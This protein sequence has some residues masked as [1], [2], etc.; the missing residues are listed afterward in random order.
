VPDPDAIR[1]LEQQVADADRDL[2]DALNRRA[3]ARATLLLARGQLAGQPTAGDWH[4]LLREPL[5]AIGAEL[6]REHGAG[7]LAAPRVPVVA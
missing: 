3:I 5:D 6:S 1:A 7:R 2:A 4:R